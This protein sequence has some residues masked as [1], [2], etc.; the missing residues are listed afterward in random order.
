MCE[1]ENRDLKDEMQ[2]KMNVVDQALQVLGEEIA[3]FESEWEA[4]KEK[5]STTTAG[6]DGR[7]PRPNRC[8]PE[9]VPLKQRC[10]KD[11]EKQNP[12]RTTLDGEDEEIDQ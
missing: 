12:G 4:K 6:R 10:S 9:G 7:A 5:E 8:G 1:F 2:E 3:R 11:C